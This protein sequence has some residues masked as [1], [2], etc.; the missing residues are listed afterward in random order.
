[1]RRMVSTAAALVWLCAAGPSSAQQLVSKI[2][3]SYEMPTKPELR[4]IYDRL[5]QRYVLEMLQAFMTPLRLPRDLTVRT[6]QCN[7][8]NVGYKPQ[9]PVTI[10]YEAI[11]EIDKIVAQHTQD[12]KMRQM[13]VTGAIMETVLHDVALATFDLLQVPIWGRLDDAADR[14]AALIMVAFGEDVAKVAITGTAQ[15]FAWTD[16]KWTGRDFS[17]TASPAYQRF[18]NYICIAYIG[19][20]LEFG[21]LVENKI[22]P[23]RRAD[24]CQREYDQ[25]RKAFNLRIMPHIDEDALVQIRATSWLNWTPPPK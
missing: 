12:A 10:C 18:F 20:P 7:V 2:Q 15:L 9:G 23:K 17:D 11:E 16:K 24:R 8:T 14:L 21:E 13:V 19:N 1:M 22:L 4:P 25:I 3:I 5:K 6:A